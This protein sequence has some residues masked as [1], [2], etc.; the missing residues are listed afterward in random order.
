MTSKMLSVYS[1]ILVVIVGLLVTALIPVHA[2]DA[3]SS[4][5]NIQDDMQTVGIINPEGAKSVWLISNSSG[6]DIAGLLAKYP[7]KMN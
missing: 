1:K 6:G 2:A 3:E 4:K 5:T 7:S